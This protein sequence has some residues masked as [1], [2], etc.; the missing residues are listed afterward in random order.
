MATSEKSSKSSK[1]EKDSTASSGSSAPKGDVGAAASEAA[2]QVQGT[3]TG[4]K[5][6]AKEQAS[7]QLTSRLETVTSGL[8]MAVKLL[9]SASDQVRE[10]EKT[11]VADSIGGVAD[12]IEGWSTTLAE[13][14]VDK[15][16]D[17]T[18]Q[19][20]QRKPALFIG[21]ATA[22]G[23]LGAR[24]LTTS[25][26]KQEE[27]SAAKS[28]SGSSSET[29]ADSTSST[30]TPSDAEFE[31]TNPYPST[32]ENAALEASLEASAT[33]DEMVI[34]DDMA[35]G[36]DVMLDDAVLEADV[37]LDDPMQGTDLPGSPLD[38][39]GTSKRPGER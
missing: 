38:R 26:K 2:E 31:N 8:D 16:V 29:A 11:G 36:S 22:L 21:G 13:Q 37:P 25:A 19:L 18:K 23:F 24:F 7:S 6:Q 30:P 15:L 1:K 35:L 4:L 20:A 3:V 5:D 28:E 32:E 34:V 33:Y 14:D 12:R 10:Q 27:A 39:R 17:E 9:R